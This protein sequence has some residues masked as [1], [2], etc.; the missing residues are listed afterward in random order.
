M[1]S[2]TCAFVSLFVLVATPAAAQLPAARP[3]P[4]HAY[5]VSELPDLGGP[6]HDVH[7]FDLNDAGEAVGYVLDAQLRWRAVRWSADGAVEDLGGGSSTWSIA[8]GI[9]AGGVVAG[10]HGPTL[11]SARPV[12]WVGGTIVVLPDPA[13]G[14]AVEAYDVDDS[15]RAVGRGYALANPFAIAWDAAGATA[16]GQPPSWAFS[17]NENGVAAGVVDVAGQPRAARWDLGVTT[18]LPG[19]GSPYSKAIGV[20]PL[21]AIAG[22]ADSPASGLTHAVVWRGSV[23][24]D[25]GAY[26]GA[27]ITTAT[28]VADDGTVV[29]YYYL[30]PLAEITR[31]LVWRGGGAS[32]DLNGLDA[33]GS[34][35]TFSDATAVNRHGWIV[36][37]G[38][39][40]GF[41]G[42]RAY[43]AK[44]R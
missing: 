18:L 44:P 21:G 34:G 32:Q 8:R 19:L 1:S 28:G 2:P 36:G 12:L 22:H 10:F 27:Y 41:P 23:V 16:I 29:G 11:E 14:P 20:S 33:P 5:D 25:L 15:L 35:W 40:S 24:T 43:V 13:L 38:T 6:W 42:M 37:R 31:A 26:L 3:A 17:S 39:R 30:D 4:Q 9:S 7:V